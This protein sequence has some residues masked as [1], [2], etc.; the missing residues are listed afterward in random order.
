[1][2]KH[3][4]TVQFDEYHTHVGTDKPMTGALAIGG[5][6]IAEKDLPILT[7]NASDHSYVTELTKLFQVTLTL[8][9][10]AL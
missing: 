9:G 7:I 8:K 2:V 6:P 4:N 5:N 3:Y 1:M 10:R